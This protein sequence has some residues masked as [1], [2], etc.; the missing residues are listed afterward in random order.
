MKDSDGNTGKGA[1]GPVFTPWDP[2]VVRDPYPQ[3]ADLQDRDPVH[4]FDAVSGWVVTRRDDCARV[5]AD[6]RFSS[7]AHES[8]FEKT[9]RFEFASPE[10]NR[11]V[12][13]F[14][15]RSMLFSDDPRHAEL[16]AMVR[17]YFAP[18]AMRFLTPRLQAAIDG[19]L[20]NLPR[21]RPFDFVAAYAEVLPLRA[22]LSV[23]GLSVRDET[24]LK[25]LI[26]GVGVLMDIVKSPDQRDHA[27]ECLVE[28]HSVVRGWIRDRRYEEDGLTAALVERCES[29][30]IAESD[31]VGMLSLLLVTGTE[32]TC[33][34]LSSAVFHL[35]AGAFG[36]VASADQQGVARFVA[37]V[38]RLSPPVMGV[39]RVAREPVSLRGRQIQP[40][41]YVIVATGAANRDPR[42]VGSCPAH[43]SFGHGAHRCL[44]AALATLQA[45]LTV[46]ALVERFVRIEVEPNPDLKSTQVLRGPRSLRTTLSAEATNQPR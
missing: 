38:L 23:L 17:D 25:A 10:Q 9:Q 2:D 13:D 34:L 42:D 33:N 41:D 22:I 8:T 37:E 19:L 43:L 27:A 14:F 16:R 31:V 5:L 45:E 36:E 21:D 4:R 15:G 12:E 3:F 35:G 40:G 6:A 28:L 39:A 29:G 20:D 1:T 24:R 7:Q 46:R 11:A 18:R 30:D 32:T 26:G 44:G